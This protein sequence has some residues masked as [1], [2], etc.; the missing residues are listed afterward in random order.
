MLHHRKS[1]LVQLSIALNIVSYNQHLPIQIVDVS[2]VVIII[3]LA[4]QIVVI[5]VVVKNDA[6]GNRISSAIAPPLS[7]CISCRFFYRT[8]ELSN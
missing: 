4:I 5:S 1:V 3:I 2:V 7:N 8:V 6:P